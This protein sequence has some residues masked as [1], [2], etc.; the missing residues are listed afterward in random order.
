MNFYSY[1]S[2]FVF[3]LTLKLELQFSKF[4][5]E[6]LKNENKTLQNL[7]FNETKAETMSYLLYVYFVTEHHVEAKMKGLKPEVCHS[8]LLG[9]KMHPVYSRMKLQ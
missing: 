3:T 4:Q 9:R 5:I 8:K 6:K 2:L 1:I 7:I